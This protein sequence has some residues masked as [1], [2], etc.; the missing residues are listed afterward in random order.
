[1]FA[2]SL[3]NDIRLDTLMVLA[4]LKVLLTFRKQELSAPTE[5][6]GSEAH[7]R[8]TAIGGDEADEGH[9]QSKDETSRIVSDLRVLVD[10]EQSLGYCVL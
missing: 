5:T 4:D 1:V 2:R 7:E 6:L 9:V 10:V 8:R 3:V